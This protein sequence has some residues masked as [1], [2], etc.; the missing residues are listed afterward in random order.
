[1]EAGS[2]DGSI[3]LLR[4]LIK[5]RDKAA[6]IERKLYSYDPF[7]DFVASYEG[8]NA[9]EPLDET[10]QLC[11]GEAYQPLRRYTLNAYGQEEPAPGYS[12]ENDVCGR[13]CP[14]GL[15]KPVPEEGE[16]QG[17]Q[18][19][20]LLLLAVK[21]LNVPL[22]PA[23]LGAEQANLKRVELMEQLP[24][25]LAEITDTGSKKE[26]PVM[27]AK[28]T[29]NEAI[30]VIHDGFVFD[31]SSGTPQPILIQA[32]NR[33]A[34]ES[35]LEYP[36]PT[37]PA[38]PTP[39]AP[40]AAPAAPAAPAPP[41]LPSP[42][43]GS[44]PPPAL[45]PSPNAVEVP[46]A[47]EAN[48]APAPPPTTAAEPEVSVP[49][50][51][52]EEPSEEAEINLSE[53]ADTIEKAETDM[54]QAVRSHM[55]KLRITLGV[56]PLGSLLEESEQE[57]EAPTKGKSTKAGAPD[58]KPEPSGPPAGVDPNDSP[59]QQIVS[60]AKS[61]FKGLT[62]E[63]MKA[64]LADASRDQLQE[65]CDLFDISTENYSEKTWE[66]S[67]KTASIKKVFGRSGNDVAEGVAQTVM[68]NA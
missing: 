49:E 14:F 3:R 51:P 6:E 67:A 20:Y 2:F 4:D 58:R 12:P 60:L 13:Q 11:L 64:I 24:T 46:P 28:I 19:C 30:H 57:Q 61:N 18:G 34:T 45:P 17:N 15:Y 59:A 9:P 53:V 50:A 63:G 27:S 52:E 56:D 21:A 1:M 8:P 44:A 31:K 22:P 40:P 43:T 23:D 38:A 39:P 35:D 5:D 42:P 16:V 10:P 62:R 29:Y 66:R 36:T 41:V 65:V 68:S 54:L 47:P 32:E 33:Y 25:W 48:T 37:P 7:L 26:T 55:D